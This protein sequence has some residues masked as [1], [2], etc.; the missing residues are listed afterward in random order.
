MVVNAAAVFILPIRKQTLFARPTQRALLLH[1]QE[2]GV[3]DAVAG[4]ITMIKI[5][6]SD[7]CH[8]FLLFNFSIPLF[9]K[10]LENSLIFDKSKTVV[11]FF[12][13]FF[14]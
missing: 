8:S 2:R 4:I 11:E 13:K 1:K 12:Y 9:L 14:V 7:V 10:I 5:K 6:K 3:L